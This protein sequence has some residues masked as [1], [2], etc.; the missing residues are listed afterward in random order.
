MMEKLAYTLD[1]IPTGSDTC[2]HSNPQIIN[3]RK[4]EVYLN[5]LLCTFYFDLED[6]YNYYGEIKVMV[7]VMT[8]DNPKDSHH[9]WITFP[10]PNFKMSVE[11]QSLGHLDDGLSLTQ[12]KTI[13]FYH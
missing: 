13:N 3:Q 12:S 6:L 1:W 7:E 5:K 2:K 11:D 8:I 9:C 10:Y 4:I